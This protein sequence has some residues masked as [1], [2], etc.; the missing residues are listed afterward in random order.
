[1]NKKYMFVLDVDG[2]FTDGT[3]HYNSEGKCEK[4]FG[5]D[6]ADALKLLKDK[7]DIVICSADHRGFPITQKRINDMGY[8]LTCVKSKDRLQWIKENCKD[9]TVAYMGDSFQDAP[10]FKGVDIGICTSDSSF[11]AKKHADYI[12]PNKGGSRAVADAVFWLAWHWFGLTPEQLVGMEEIKK[13][14]K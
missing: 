11:L 14:G 9:S 7:V 13:E 10:I 2:I 1:M 4:V 5:P 8:E 12:T 3:F 6:D